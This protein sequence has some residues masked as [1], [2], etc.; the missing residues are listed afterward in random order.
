MRRRR[1]ATDRARVVGAQ[2]PITYPRGSNRLQGDGVL[3]CLGLILDTWQALDGASAEFAEGMSHDFSIARGRAAQVCSIAASAAMGDACWVGA[4][5]GP[6][7]RSAAE[8]RTEL[9]FLGDAAQ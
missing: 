8:H 1:R 2:W 7:L 5:P 4:K 9:R 3:A 6:A